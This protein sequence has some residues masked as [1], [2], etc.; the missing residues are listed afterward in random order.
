VKNHLLIAG[1]LL[2]AL[3]CVGEQPRIGA[4]APP[5]ALRD[6]EGHARS[7]RDFRGMPVVLC[8][9]CG[10]PLCRAFARAWA[11]EQGAAARP[12]SLPAGAPHRRAKSRWVA[13]SQIALFVETGTARSLR[14]FAREAGLAPRRSVLLLDP[15][16]RAARRYGVTGCPRVFVL[17]TGSTVR[18]TAARSVDSRATGAGRLVEGIVVVLR[19]MESAVGS[20]TDR[21]TA[22][23]P[24]EDAV[25]AAGPPR[26]GDRAEKGARP[27][28]SAAVP[29]APGRS[30][31]RRTQLGV[32]AG[33]GVR[34]TAGGAELDFGRIDASAVAARQC[35]VT[36]RNSGPRPVTIERAQPSCSCL[37][38]TLLQDGDASQTMTLLPGDE[39]ELRVRLDA[40]QLLPGTIEKSVW[41]FERGR[42]E[43]AFTIEVRA[44]SMRGP[45]NQH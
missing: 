43:P 27:R 36:V 35:V 45:A 34:A 38:A 14:A 20:G 1:M 16:G 28:S 18:Y 44:V 9:V 10:C 5:L 32:V 30:A 3:P 24:A 11:N 31:A 2:M 4:G 21:H 23:T 29:M 13:E 8:F 17:D 37:T 12:A 41:L 33:S 7:L 15:G 40:S 26:K 19:S 6:T 42:T 22:L 39:A 25:Q